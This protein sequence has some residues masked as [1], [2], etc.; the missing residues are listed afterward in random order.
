MSTNPVAPYFKALVGFV[1]PGA[2][3]IGSAVVESSPA[4]QTITGGEWVTAVVACIVTGAA[5][6]RTPNRDPEGEHQDEYV[7]PPDEPQRILGKA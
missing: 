6:Y 4:G 2:V 3:V 1:A 7:Q 5:V